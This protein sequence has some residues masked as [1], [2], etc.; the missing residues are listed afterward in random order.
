MSPDP[1]REIALEKLIKKLFLTGQVRVPDQALLA[2]RIVSGGLPESAKS[3]FL[4]FRPVPGSGKF[5]KQFFTANSDPGNPNPGSE[6]RNSGFEKSESGFLDFYRPSGFLP[7]VQIT[8]LSYSPDFTEYFSGLPEA[9][10][11]PIYK[12]PPTFLYI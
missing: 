11:T 5:G 10:Y 7:G 8:E 6:F 1:A 9:H 4:I 2:P 12:K 3:V